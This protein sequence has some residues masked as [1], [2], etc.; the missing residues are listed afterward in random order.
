M[1][2]VQILRHILLDLEHIVDIAHLIIHSLLVRGILPVAIHYEFV[3][4]QIIILSAWQPLQRWHELMQL[5]ILQNHVPN[6]TKGT[7]MRIAITVSTIAQP[8]EPGRGFHWR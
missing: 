3:L 1:Q 6:D 7:Q 5:M 8:I 4:R 2:A